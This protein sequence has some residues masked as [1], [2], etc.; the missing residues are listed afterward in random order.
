MPVYDKPMIYYPLATLMQSGIRD[1]SGI[2]TPRDQIAYAD[3]LG[4]GSQWGLSIQYTIQENPDG[5][6]QAFIW[7]STSLVR[8]RLPGAGRQHLLRL[9]SH[10]LGAC[11]AH[12]GASV[13]AYYVQDPQR[14]GVIEFD[15]EGRAIGIEEKPAKPRSHYAVTGLYFY[16][17]DV[18]SSPRASR[19]RNAVSSRSLTSITLP[20]ARRAQVEVSGIGHGLA[21][22]VPTSHYWTPGISLCHRGASRSSKLPVW[23]RLPTDRDTSMQSKLWHSQVR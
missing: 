23:R 20:G 7:A 19:P 11:A 12:G 5:L 6:A 16:D 3:L 18:I 22:H 21:G 9:A 1:I 15:S 8:I 13:F 17:N 4:D 2:T 10:P 14:Y